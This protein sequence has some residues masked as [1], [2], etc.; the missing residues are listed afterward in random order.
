MMRC[1][2]IRMF[3]H[4]RKSG[5]LGDYLHHK[6]DCGYD[7]AWIGR[8]AEDVC[9]KW[10]QVL[11]Y[12]LHNDFIHHIL[13]TVKKKKNNKK[14]RRVQLNTSHNLM[15]TVSVL[16]KWSTVEGWRKSH[17][18]VN[19]RHETEKE[20]EEKQPHVEVIRSRGFENSFVRNVTC[21]HCPALVIHGAQQTQHVDAHQPRGVKCT[22]PETHILFATGAVPK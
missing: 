9:H 12:S 2:T 21:H 15:C 22:H 14:N 13:T 7:E 8:I 18:A 5:S 4:I 17:N 6:Q 3:S 20:D 1:N 11:F 10:W 16:P 19:H